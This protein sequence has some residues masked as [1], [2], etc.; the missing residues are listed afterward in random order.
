[1]HSVQGTFSIGRRVSEDDDQLIASPDDGPYS[2]SMNAIAHW[3]TFPQRDQIDQLRP[4]PMILIPI[5]MPDPLR[6]TN[7]SE[8]MY[9]ACSI[10]GQSIS[11]LSVQISKDSGWDTPGLASIS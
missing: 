9:S 8:E 7:L 10:Y 1:M 5:G 11:R 6:I 2:V 4:H 3:V